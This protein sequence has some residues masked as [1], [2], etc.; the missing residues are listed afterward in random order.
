MAT[1]LSPESAPEPNEPA[2]ES[3]APERGRV[4]LSSFGLR[5]SRSTTAEGTISAVVKVSPQS[6]P[7]GG[8]ST[9]HGP[10]KAASVLP[11]DYQTA[12][13]DEVRSG[14][15]IWRLPA[16][17]DQIRLGL[18]A[19]ATGV[20]ALGALV[21]SIAVSG[22]TFL[23]AR[24][25]YVQERRDAVERL[26]FTNAAD[27]ISGVAQVDQR[28]DQVIARQRREDA[29]SILRSKRGEYSSDDGK[30]TV[31]KSIPPGIVKALKDGA[32][33]VHQ[34]VEGP[35]GSELIVGVALPSV[36]SEFYQVASLQE[37]E[38]NLKRLGRALF[39]AAMA[40][41][42]GAALIG[43]SV[44]RR[45]VQPIRD[46]ADAAAGIARGNL[47]TRLE[48]S[49][50]ADLD[51]LLH[52]FNTM[53]ESLQSR[54]EREARFAS[55]VSHELRTPLT[56]LSTAAQLLNGRRDELSERGQKT[57]DVLVTQTV[58][59]ERLVLDLL[60]ISRFDAGAA[61]LNAEVVDLVHLVEQV[62]SLHGVDVE[63]DVESLS[64]RLL[65]LDKRRVE[66]IV[67][68]LLQNATNYAGGA[69]AVRIAD[70]YRDPLTGEYVDGPSEDDETYP[71]DLRDELQ[72]VV[73]IAV[74]DNGPGVPEEEQV[75]I[76]ERF[77]RG[78]AH[79][80]GT[81]AQKGTGLGLSLVRA[82]ALLHQGDVWVE[83]V[84]PKGAR[85]VV[86][87]VEADI[88][89]DADFG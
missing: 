7:A 59:F 23:V 19:R 33:A 51:P 28:L 3:K 69:T 11:L 26:A 32:A 72:H 42:L 5:E 13:L 38:G 68:N 17:F 85:F 73:R 44:S 40:S 82:H 78:Q 22:L 30:S 75:A 55:D 67:A 1:D 77:R 83:N 88:D 36:S 15:Q 54:I 34:T 81:F 70:A 2:L 50:D 62:V 89:I 52:S 24:S 66:R 71:D 25:S 87:L 43:R 47:D 49:G 41:T 29:I 35:N 53:A 37:V 18:R 45:V 86:E 56:A 79:Q 9:S 4:G 16:P 21:L 8:L 20:L 64:T 60:E 10:E 65:A 63:L 12:N 6:S 31:A 61:E 57:L 39:V 14:V 76:F 58:H 84:E 80:R 46:V 27:A 48:L 74:E